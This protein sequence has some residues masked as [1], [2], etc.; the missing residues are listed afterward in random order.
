MRQIRE[1]KI[2][3]RFKRNDRGDDKIVRNGGRH[4]CA[5]AC[6]CHPQIRTQDTL[7]HTHAQKMFSGLHCLPH[8]YLSPQTENQFVSLTSVSLSVHFNKPLM[9]FLSGTLRLFSWG[10]SNKSSLSSLIFKK[11]CKK[12]GKTHSSRVTSSWSATLCSDALQRI[13]AC[14]RLRS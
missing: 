13:T 10:H 9:G 1:G 5:K 14:W 6:F 12:A 7:T 4:L 11:T 2:F 3:N 8:G